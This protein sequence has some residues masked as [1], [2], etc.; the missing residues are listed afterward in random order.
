MNGESEACATG[1]GQASG[2]RNWR[3]LIEPFTRADSR[4]GT[5]ELIC[6]VLPFFGL[7]AAMFYGLHCEIWAVLAL[8][9]PAAAF[10]VRLFIIQHDCGHGSYFKSRRMNDL[11]GRVIGVFTLTP[12]A[13]WRQDHAVHHATSGNLSRRGVGD[14]T[15]LTVREYL[16]RP[17][18]NRLVYRLYRHPLVLF[19]IGP[20]YQFLLV[21]RVPR[22]SPVK[23]R[24]SWLSILGTNAALAAIAVA[25]TLLLG[26]RPLVMGY[27]PVIMLAG[28]IGIW[29]FY[30][31]HQFESTYWEE[32]PHW[33]FQAAAF[34]GCS[35]YD[36]PGFLHWL[37]GHI[38]FHHI[39]H[40]AIRIPSYRLRAAFDAVPAFREAKRLRLGESLGCSRL[41]LW[42]ERRRKLVRFADA[43]N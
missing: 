27:L 3:E 1:P 4:R 29:L 20:A 30:V 9:L 6:T 12:Y 10:L 43:R 35:L 31:Q 14:I 41:V 19:G 11:L 7:V 33:D 39:H 16:S 37:T 34:E 18:L 40:L 15:T 22:G 42:D 24:K 2:T 17:A 38:G 5:L 28:S 32:E 25:V 21:H 23:N 13:F 8:V 36:L 26:W